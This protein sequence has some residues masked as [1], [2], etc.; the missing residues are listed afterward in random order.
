MIAISLVGTVLMGSFK[1][2][3][4]VSKHAISMNSPVYFFHLPFCVPLFHR[5][6]FIVPLYSIIPKGTLCCSASGLDP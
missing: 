5:L 1:G 2:Y 6:N 4:M 3:L